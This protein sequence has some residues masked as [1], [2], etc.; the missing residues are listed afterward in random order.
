[1]KK[2]KG[3][4][5]SLLLVSSVSM[6]DVLPKVNDS[7][8]QTHS[9]HVVWDRTPIEFVA[10]INNERMIT[11]PGSVIF[12]NTS[13]QLTSDR[14]SI[15]NNA[16][17]LYITAKKSFPPIRVSVQMKK[18]G[19]VI[20]MDIAGK[21][22]ADASPVTVLLSQKPP[23][24]GHQHKMSSTAINYVTLMRYATQHLY[25]PTRL[26]HDDA[27]IY[28]TAMY[29]SKSVNLFYGDKTIALPLMSWQ[30]GDLYVT[31]V[32]V[33]NIMHHRIHLVPSQIHG[34]WLAE[35]LYPNS[36]LQSSGQSRDRCTVFLVSTKPF[37]QALFS[38]KDYSND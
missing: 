11:F 14:V 16:G 1:M 24:S 13:S 9:E 3:L 4:I 8:A 26:V 6:A 10:P 5:L 18:T 36:L 21:K 22:N 27:D 30:G 35:S 23:P 38:M 7:V 34:S 20:L 17:T 12:K 28:R 2:V 31:A 25:S 32:L 15:L 37:N 19:E 33:K 29:T